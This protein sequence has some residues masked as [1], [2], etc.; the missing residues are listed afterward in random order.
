MGLAY[1]RYSL[2][3][4]QLVQEICVMGSNNVDKRLSTQTQSNLHL[5]YVS[6]SFVVSTNPESM[7]SAS[8]SLDLILNTVSANH[9]V[10]IPSPHDDDGDE[11]GDDD[12]DDNGDD[13]GDDDIS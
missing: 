8:M 2:H 12:G 6:P 7:K 11:D 13:D 1:D 10:R 9:Q 4:M 5:Q 3:M